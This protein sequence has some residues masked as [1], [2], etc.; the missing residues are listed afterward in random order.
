MSAIMPLNAPSKSAGLVTILAYISVLTVNLTVW[1]PV[2]M[3][4]SACPLV[5][6]LSLEAGRTDL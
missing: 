3:S 4:Y 2:V 5:R 1:P 6:T